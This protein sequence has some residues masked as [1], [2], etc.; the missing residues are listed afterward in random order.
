MR[1]GEFWEAMNAY[2]AE[3]NADRQHIGELIRG[4]AIR[5]FNTQVK[6]PITRVQDFWSFPWDV[7]PED[8]NASE[9]HRLDALTDDERQAEAQ[10]FLDRINHGKQSKSE[11]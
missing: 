1:V 8:F 11:N 4:A 10:K 2:S 3:K 6:K 5:L 9:I 7:N